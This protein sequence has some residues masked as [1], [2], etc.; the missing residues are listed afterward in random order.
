MIEMNSCI[1]RYDLQSLIILILLLGKKKMLSWPYLGSLAHV[2]TQYPFPPSFLQLHNLHTYCITVH[3]VICLMASYM[4]C[5][6][7]DSPPPLTS[8]VND[9]IWFGLE[10]LDY[11]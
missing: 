4:L 5:N 1:E 6:A 8:V 7:N 10:C 11:F 2:V 9:Q 3:T